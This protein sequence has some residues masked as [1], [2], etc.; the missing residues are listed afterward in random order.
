MGR[1][2]LFFV[3]LIPLLLP[4]PQ[5]PSQSAS[6][7]ALNRSHN[8]NGCGEFVALLSGSVASFM[9]PDRHP[10][11]RAEQLFL[12]VCSGVNEV[13][14]FF[15]CFCFL[16]KKKATNITKYWRNAE[17]MGTASSGVTVRLVLFGVSLP[18][19]L[20]RSRSFSVSCCLLTSPNWQGKHTHTHTCTNTVIGL[21]H[22]KSQYNL[23]N[24]SSNKC[25]TLLG[26]HNIIAREELQP[27]VEQIKI[28][29]QTNRFKVRMRV[30]VTRRVG[31][32]GCAT[33]VF[34]VIFTLSY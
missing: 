32:G 26:L 7:S 21:W 29:K 2:R 27:K 28:G 20:S 23:I 14:K 5:S 16:H 1:S 30:R 33:W 22:R 25:T 18:V 17:L 6:Q 31:S 12:C 19:A 34:H 15:V 9:D 3:F 8:F 13:N 24:N 10:S 11:A 4:L